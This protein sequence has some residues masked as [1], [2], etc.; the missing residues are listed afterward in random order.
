MSHKHQGGLPYCQ[1]C[2]YPLAEM[3]KFCPNCG[4]KNTDGHVSLHDLWHELSHY[5]THVDNK[6]FVTIRDVFIPGKLTEEFFKGHRKRYIH[7]IN[8]FFVMGILLPIVMGKSLKEAFKGT[9]GGTRLM[10]DRQIYRNDLLFEIDSIVKQDSVHFNGETRQK[11]DSLL[12]Q[13]YQRSNVYFQKDKTADSSRIQFYALLDKIKD[14]HTAVNLLSDTVQIDRSFA[15]KPLIQK[16]LAD[17]QNYVIKLQ[18]DSL[19]VVSTYAQHE[20]I[21]LV[22]AESKLQQGYFASNF[23]KNLA[24]KGIDIKPL[25]FDSVMKYPVDYDPVQTYRDSN[26]RHIKRD[27]LNVGFVV[28]KETKI[29]QLDMANLSG[30][31]IV[32]KYNI[33]GFWQKIAVQQFIKLGNQGLNGITSVFAN[34]SVWITVFTILPSAWFLL[35]LYRRQKRL[36]VE[37]VVFLIHYNCMVFIFSILMLL[38]SDWGLYGS[39]ILG[40]IF[41]VFAFKR[42]YQQNWGKTILK[43]IIYYAASTVLSII[44][45]LLGF[46]LSAV[47][48]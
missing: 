4:Q 8:F 35:F 37:H 18:H 13:T 25:S 26:R 20:K 19:I 38:K 31:E 23:G 47:F 27:S 32:D 11:V 5:F 1:N 44:I 17:Y 43:S 48:M 40:F 6:I 45:S 10:S 9:G 14:A 16:R 22:E 34:S 28:G 15:D 2:H 12:I 39:A 36:Y 46:V 42:F 41:L 3:D 24:K 33:T 7:P 30:S 29:S 21:T